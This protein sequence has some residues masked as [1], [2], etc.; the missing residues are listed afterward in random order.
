MPSP[1]EIELVIA[2]TTAFLDRVRYPFLSWLAKRIVRLC[3][4]AV[5]VVALTLAQSKIF[6]KGESAR[7]CR[8][9]AI[10][11]VIEL[12]FGLTQQEISLCL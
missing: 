7:G 2:N 4:H 3:K 11:S 1:Q 12:H 6:T 9:Q 5:G 10:L 8:L